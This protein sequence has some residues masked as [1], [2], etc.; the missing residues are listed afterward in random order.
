MMCNLFP[1]ADRGSVRTLFR[2]CLGGVMVVSLGAAAGLHADEPSDDLQ[3]VSDFAGG[4]VEVAAIDQESRTIR[5]SPATHRDLGWDCWWYFQVTG[6]RPGEELTLDLRGDVWSTPKHAA[7]SLDGKKWE[8]TAAGNRIDGGIVYRQKIDGDTAWFAW[9]PPF[10]PEDA[11]QLVDRAARTAP[12]AEAFRLCETRGGRNTPALRLNALA[13]DEPGQTIVWIQARQHAWECGS[14]WVCRG[15]VEWLI[16]DDKR[17]QS[18]RRTTSFVIVPVMDID[19][20][21]IGAGGKNQKPQ[22]HNRDWTDEP[23][24]RAV[25]AAQQEILKLDE[26][27][28]L[29][30]FIDLHN[31]DAHSQDPF[32]F[33]A[34]KE[35]LDATGQKNLTRFL[36]S[37][38]TEMTG[39]LRFRGQVRESGAKYDRRWKAISKNWV[40]T[41][42]SPHVV[43]VTLETAWNTP[44]SNTAGY[45]QVGRELGQSLA[46]FL[47]EDMKD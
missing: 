20:V 39:P 31:P 41:H 4:S 17:V 45:Q 32:F 44:H 27:G 35:L 29:A 7:F 12:A 25:A 18:L 46:R 22:D 30:A 19:N 1:R 23:Y 37:V 34:P 16:S 8:Q 42:T 10:L 13:P 26:E 15:L 36:K 40:A 6:I 9:G 2:L 21:A 5:F 38:R 11:Q 3:V 33:I 43:S 28:R 14:S 24:W 47:N